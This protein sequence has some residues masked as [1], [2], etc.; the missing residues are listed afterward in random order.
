[1]GA[2]VFVTTSQALWAGALGEKFL[3]PVTEATDSANTPSEDSSRLWMVAGGKILHSENAGKT[4]HT[5]SVNVASGATGPEVRLEVQPEVH[6]IREVPLE[7]QLPEPRSGASTASAPAS[8]LLLAGTTKGLYRRRADNP[9]WQLVQN[10]LPAGEPISCFI[11]DGVWVVAMQV[12][13]LYVSR[14]AS[15][16]WE[17]LDTGSVAG[18]FTGASVTPDGSIV[19]ASLT[20]GLLRYPLGNVD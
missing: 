15:Q 11:G 14:D 7:V 5:E 13:G 8:T 6:W 19:A 1:M 17:R 4:W 2:R 3:R 9:A 18:Q 16:T 20:E 12:G 10:G